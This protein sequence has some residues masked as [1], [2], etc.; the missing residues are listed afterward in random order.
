MHCD[1]KSTPVLVQFNK[2]I[3]GSGISKPGVKAVCSGQCKNCP[4]N[5]HNKS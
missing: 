2:V 1:K 5:T 3:L 4:N